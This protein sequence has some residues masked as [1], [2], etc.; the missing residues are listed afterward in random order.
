MA[1]TQDL[2]FTDQAA[3]SG[4]IDIQQGQ[5][6]LSASPTFAVAQFGGQLAAE[7]TSLN[8]QLAGIL[9]AEGLPQP[10]ALDPAIQ[11]SIAT[12]VNLYGPN[13]NEAFLTDEIT[14]HQQDIANYRQ[15]T[16]YGQDPSLRQFAAATLPV[17]QGELNSAT[18]LLNYD[19][20]GFLG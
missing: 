15:E 20:Q 10:T 16:L 13:S 1:N 2:Q 18:T 14:G 6:A 8:A 5:L 19:Y 17:L 12:E 3:T 11:Y 9:Q 4:V 7:H